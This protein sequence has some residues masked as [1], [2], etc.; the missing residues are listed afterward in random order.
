MSKTLFGRP[1]IHLVFIALLG[2]LVYSNTFNSSFHFDDYP[3]IV[4]NPIVKDLSYFI[5]PSKAKG[6]LEAVRHE[7]YPVFKQRFIGFLTFAMNYKIHS[8]N[9]T[10]YHIINLA[11]HIL[12]AFLVYQLVVLTFRTSF[13]KNSSLRENARFIALFSAV[14]FVSHPMQTQAI[15]YISQRFASLA[16]MFYLLSFSSYVASR[17]STQRTGQ[18]TFYAV[19]LVSVVLAMKTKENSFTLPVAIAMY[20]FMFF[21][22]LSKGPTVRSHW[23]TKGAEGGISLHEGEG[24]GVRIDFSLRRRLLF[25][26]P[27]FLTM[28]IIP[29]SILDV[30]R[31]IGNLIGEVSAATRLQT[32]MTRADYLLT[33]FTVITTY[34]RLLFLPIN[35]NLDYDYPVYHSFF[36]PPVFLS[37]L[38]LLSIFGLGVYC[39]CRSRVM[40]R[41]SK[42]YSLLITDHS[43]RLVAFGIFWFFITLSVESSVIPITDIIFEHRVYL[44]SVGAFLAFG[45]GVFLLIESLKRKAARNAA[46]SFLVI[47]PL[48]LSVATYVRNSVWKTEISLWEDVIGKSSGKARGY[49][50]L[51]LAFTRKG[52]NEKAMKYYRKSL[53]LKPNDIEALNNLGISY[54]NMGQ[55]D[56]AVELYLHALRL[57]PDHPETHNNLG[58]AYKAKGSSDKAIE[59]YQIALKLRSDYAEAHYNLGYIY[60]DMGLT[61]IAIRHYQITLTL[62][63]DFADAHNNLG[64]AYYKKGQVD[65]A[66]K[67]LRV[68]LKL[69]PNYPDAH[70][71]IAVVYRFIG[72]S[73][74]AIEHFQT[75]V[76]IRPDHAGAH[77][78]LGLIYLKQGLQNKARRK[79]EAALQIDPAHQ[80]ARRYLNLIANPDKARP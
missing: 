24:K 63:P 74:K 46:F 67:H 12:N 72:Q 18:Y 2:L 36:E 35:Q 13:M 49:G 51:G 39:L 7:L 15:T 26:L 64:I 30:D 44:P 73:D 50:A 29:L 23:F 28:I 40:N 66:L 6:P 14:L 68:A 3:Y 4:E 76:R 38:F 77:Y 65:K 17:F 20:E 80:Q 59:H 45:T 32:D 41:N 48:V 25:L 11:V 56:K 8:T 78:N 16:A 33:Q 37:F 43:L 10:G 21:T 53:Q 55:S 52:S 5:E 69:K 27:F 1:I 9:V 57:N 62:N 71:N 34:I 31:P 61:D 58:N 42:I 22:P 19:S 75:A 70:Y 54:L 60:G 79:F 47:V